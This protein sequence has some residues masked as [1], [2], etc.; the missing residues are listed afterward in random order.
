MELKRRRD[1]DDYDFD[2]NPLG[3]DCYY[4]YV[5]CIVIILE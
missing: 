4:T 3:Y 2:G 5:S 1:M